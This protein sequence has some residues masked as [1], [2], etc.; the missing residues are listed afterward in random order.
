VQTEN[1]ECTKVSVVFQYVNW[2]K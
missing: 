1:N 2:E